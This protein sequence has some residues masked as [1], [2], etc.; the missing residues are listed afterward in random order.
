M[1]FGNQ[2]L[3]LRAAFHVNDPKNKGER[4]SPRETMMKTGFAPFLIITMAVLVLSGIGAAVTMKNGAQSETIP[5]HVEGREAGSKVTDHVMTQIVYP[6]NSIR[7]SYTVV[8]TDADN[9]YELLGRPTNKIPLFSMYPCGT[10]AYCTSDYWLIPAR[11]TT[12]GG[13][14]WPG[15]C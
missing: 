1:S 13:L 12:A 4:S 5:L 10:S 8:T 7:Y 3:I 11:T 14:C 2:D 15:P 9:Y 6:D